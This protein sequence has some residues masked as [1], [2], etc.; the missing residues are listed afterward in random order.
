MFKLSTDVSISRYLIYYS[1]FSK[2]TSSKVSSFNNGP[3]LFWSCVSSVMEFILWWILFWT[4]IIGSKQIFL[5]VNTM[6]DSS[7]KIGHDF[8][9]SGFSWPTWPPSNK[10][11]NL[12][13]A[14]LDIIMCENFFPNSCYERLKLRS[15][16]L[17]I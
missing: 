6:N 12:T 1:I 11:N 13:D 9:K 4:K 15:I 17:I 5:F 16:F 2:F 3:Q 14:K 8:R 10:F 7:S